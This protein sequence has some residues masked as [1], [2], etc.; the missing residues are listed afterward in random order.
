MFGPPDLKGWIVGALLWLAL[1]LAVLN[2]HIVHSG[3]S[4]WE[5]MWFFMSLLWF[6]FGFAGL[7]NTL[8]KRRHHQILDRLL[9][10][11]TPPVLFYLGLEWLMIR[12]GA[13]RLVAP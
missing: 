6:Q 7:F 1:S 12:A 4:H 3:G 11:L 9:I 2:A 10:A 13:L 8:L 5:E